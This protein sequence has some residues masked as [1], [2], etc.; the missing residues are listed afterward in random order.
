MHLIILHTRATN[1]NHAS[2]HQSSI[3]NKSNMI[4]VPQ[5]NPD[6][7]SLI[8][9]HKT[10]KFPRTT[11]L[12]KLLQRIKPSNLPN[13]ISPPKPIGQLLNLNNLIFKTNSKF[14]SH[15]LRSPLARNQ[16]RQFRFLSLN[17]PF[18]FG[19]RQSRVPRYF[20]NKS[21]II[22]HKPTTNPSFKRIPLI[23]NRY[24]YWEK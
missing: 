19:R 5:N 14:S 22:I 6:I 20:I 13:N 9:Q 10:G 12:R 2:M 17:L 15:N 16:S 4:R 18:N 3:F 23:H 21:R 11:I 1:L 7:R 24:Q 8:T